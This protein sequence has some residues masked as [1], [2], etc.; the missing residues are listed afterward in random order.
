M[1]LANFFVRG[2]EGDMVVDDLIVNGSITLNGQKLNPSGGNTDLPITSSDN[3][4]AVSNTGTD[5]NISS[6][7]WNKTAGGNINVGDNELQNVA[8]A[9]V[10]Q[11]NV[12]QMQFQNGG[13]NLNFQVNPN[14]NGLSVSN[15]GTTYYPVYDANFNKPA[16]N[17]LTFAPSAGNT[18]TNQVSQGGLLVQGALKVSNG[19]S[20]GQVYDDTV[21]PPPSS[22]NTNMKVIS[23]ASGGSVAGETDIYVGDAVNYTTFSTNGFGAILTRLHVSSLQVATQVDV[24]GSSQDGNASFYLTNSATAEYDAKLGNAISVSLQGASTSP[25]ELFPSGATFWYNSTS[26]I[27]ALYLNYTITSPSLPP[28]GGISIEFG[29][30]NL[31][32]VMECFNTN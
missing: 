4:I 7:W 10:D 12:Q 6:Q 31:Y 32:G 3:S 28:S 2:N 5:Y 30:A 8:L 17:N 21:H 16:F 13:K 1:S 20:T 22:A 9:S 26:A 14:T 29:G 23:Y 19:T 11:L 15:D 25:Y 18:P 27:T 24:A